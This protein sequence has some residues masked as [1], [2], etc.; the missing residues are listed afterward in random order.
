MARISTNYT[1]PQEKAYFLRGIPAISSS[2]L[3][4]CLLEYSSHDRNRRI[5]R[6]RCVVISA[7]NKL[8]LRTRN[9]ETTPP[10]PPLLPCAVAAAPLVFH[11]IRRETKIKQR[12]STQGIGVGCVNQQNPGLS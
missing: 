4:K 9:A 12:L 1:S 3:Y 10:P 5:H 8:Q 6:P 7:T 11:Q 2:H